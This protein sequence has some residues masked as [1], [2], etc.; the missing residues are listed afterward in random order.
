MAFCDGV[1]ALVGKGR[2]TDVIYLSLRIDVVQ[3]DILISEQEKYR[4][5]GWSTQWIKS[6]LDGH[7]QRVVVHGSMSR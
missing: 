4:S 6:W 3:H 5:E 2:A 1:A 7:S